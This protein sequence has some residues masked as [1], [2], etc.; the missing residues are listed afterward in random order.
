M[1]LVLILTSILFSAQSFAFGVDSCEREVAAKILTI[2]EVDIKLEK[3]ASLTEDR[4]RI[5]TR[6]EIRAINSENT[7]YFHA[8]QMAETVCDG[9]NP[10]KK[11]PREDE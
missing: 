3:L 8:H 7:I 10:I 2:K 11:L 6:A 9:L 1:R 4:S 5:N